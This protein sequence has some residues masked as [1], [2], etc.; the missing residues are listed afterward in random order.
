M[1]ARCVAS[2]H[3]LLF[4]FP[5]RFSLRPSAYLGSLCG[6]AFPEKVFSAALCVSRRLCGNGYLT[7]ERAE[8][9]RE[10][11]RRTNRLRGSPKAEQGNSPKFSK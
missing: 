4:L 3:I 1:V 6:K 8:I 11:Q 7:A 10:P 2:T 9:R 5:R